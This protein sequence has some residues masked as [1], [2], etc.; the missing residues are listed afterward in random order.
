M[1]NTAQIIIATTCILSVLTGT[2]ILFAGFYWTT[3]LLFCIGAFCAFVL[4]NHAQ[5]VEEQAIAKNVSRET[6]TKDGK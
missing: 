2:L 3:A 1:S 6:S 5:S 4:Q